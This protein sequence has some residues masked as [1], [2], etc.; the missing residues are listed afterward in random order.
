MGQIRSAILRAFLF[1]LYGLLFA[2]GGPAI[3]QY[4]VGTIP[5]PK[6]Y[7]QDYYVSNPNRILSAGVVDSL[8][9][10]ARLVEAKTSA[11][12]AVVVVDDFVGDDDF[13]F[14]L[15]LF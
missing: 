2:T 12:L 10:L 14:A 8:N 11:E 1:A 6:E 3:A 4:D 5:S 15:D 7:G 9:R 13:Q